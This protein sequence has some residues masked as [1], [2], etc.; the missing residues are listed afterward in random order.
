MITKAEV[1][2]L[3]KVATEEKAKLEGQIE[4]LVDLMR[5]ISQKELQLEE[6]QKED[7]KP[8]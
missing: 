1:L 7:K 4:L 3:L 5:V 2:K 8:E 6:Q